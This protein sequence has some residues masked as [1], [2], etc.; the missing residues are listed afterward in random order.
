MAELPRQ[1]GVLRRDE[2]I[3]FNGA[4][5]Q[6]RRRDIGSLLVYRVIGNDDFPLFLFTGKV[7]FLS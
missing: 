4:G 1:S 3:A 6:S 7:Q 5:E 2:I